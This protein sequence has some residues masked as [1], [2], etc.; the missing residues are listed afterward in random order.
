M[1][2]PAPGRG[3]GQPS[4]WLQDVARAGPL[5]ADVAVGLL[6]RAQMLADQGDWEIAASTFARVVG[7]TDAALHTAAL[8]GLAECRYRLDDEPAALQAWIS[9]TQAPENPLTWRAWKA[10]AAARVRSDDMAGAARSYREAARRAP[11]SEQA[12]LQSRIGWLSKESGDERGA[13]RAFSRSRTGGLAPPLVTY[14]LLAVTVV[15]GLLTLT[16]G[17]DELLGWLQ[18]DKFA[19]WSEQQY[20]RLFTVTLVHGSLIHLMFNMY[21]LWIIGPV[22][23]ALYG[24]VRYLAIY[25]LCAAAGSA[26]SYAV[27]PNPA[28]GASG[29][30]FGLFGALLV[31]DRV[32]KPALTRNAR[33]LT[34]Q[35]GILIGI[36]LVIGL[37]LPGIDNAAHIGGLLAGAWLGFVMVPVGARLASFWS[38]PRVAGPGGVGGPMLGAPSDAP[39]T[40][41]AERLLRLAGVVGLAF[42]ILLVVMLGPFLWQPPPWLTWDGQPGT[43]GKAVGDAVTVAASLATLV[44]RGHLGL[45]RLAL[46]G[47]RMRGRGLD[48]QGYGQGASRRR[49]RTS[50]AQ[51]QAQPDG[52]AVDAVEPAVDGSERDGIGTPERV[53]A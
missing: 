50:V 40:G 1:T 8:L 44:P 6:Q 14:G 53:A 49:G 23:E 28:V 24:P 21:A 27:S 43:I 48:G 12:E 42:V 5:D 51:R 10:L 38:R 9:A 46:V 52:R 37:S 26:A 18:L 31:A 4:S 45:G 17:Q 41:Q 34:A 19:I 25:L 35:I 22:V 11:A 2:D 15:V 7:S 30:V 33:N 39:S 29:A 13:Q 20:W 32:H 16:G 36:N 47:R 3:S